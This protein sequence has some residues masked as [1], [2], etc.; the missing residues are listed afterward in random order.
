MPGKA[1]LNITLLWKIELK[2]NVC[3]IHQQPADLM[4]SYT[5][6]VLPATLCTRSR[7]VTWQR[8]RAAGTHQ[9]QHLEWYR[10]QR[11]GT[12]RLTLGPTAHTCC[13]AFHRKAR[14]GATSPGVAASMMLLQVGP[15]CRSRVSRTYSSAASTQLLHTVLSTCR[16]HN[17]VK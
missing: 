15:E 8:R 1:L 4:A 2:Y 3:K 16:A 11:C 6:A 17:R 7:T 9:Q 13:S 14:E 12:G 5:A 10:Y